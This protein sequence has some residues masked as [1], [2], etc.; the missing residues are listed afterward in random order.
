M[1]QSLKTGGKGNACE[2]EQEEKASAVR[3]IV[4]VTTGTE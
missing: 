1:T 2:D 4:L 3:P